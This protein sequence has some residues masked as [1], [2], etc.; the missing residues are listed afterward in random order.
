MFARIL[1]ALP[2]PEREDL[3]EVIRDLLEPGDEEGHGP[4]AYWAPTTNEADALVTLDQGRFDLL[5][6][7]LHLPANR[8][9]PRNEADRRGL[10]LLRTLRDRGDDTPCVLLSPSVNP[11]LKQECDRIAACGVAQ[12]G[13]RFEKGFKAALAQA[14]GAGRPAADPADA[15]PVAATPAER[16][17]AEIEIRFQMPV[18]T[19]KVAITK[20]AQTYSFSGH[21]SIDLGSLQQLTERRGKEIS[22]SLYPRWEKVL[23]DIGGVVLRALLADF[24]LR[25]HLVESVKEVGGLENTRIR[26][27]VHPRIHPL[28]LEALIEEDEDAKFWMLQAAVTR[29]LH[30]HIPDHAGGSREGSRQ[31]PDRLNCLIIRADATGFIDGVGNLRRLKNVAKE[32]DWLERFL[33]NLD[34]ALPQVAFGT[35]RVIGGIESDPASFL[36]ELQAALT[37]GTEWHLIHFAGHSYLDPQD[38]KS[39]LVVPGKEPVR[40]AVEEFA[41]WA[42]GARLIYVSSCGGSENQVILDLAANGIPAVLGFRWDIEDD[43][44][45]EHARIFYRE[46]LT[47]RRPIDQAFLEARKELNRR[48]QT[49]RIWAA[50]ILLLQDD[51]TF[52]TQFPTTPL[53]AAS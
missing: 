35:P 39:Y 27:T 18:Q 19:Y 21:C 25:Q 7:H 30:M 43:R 47:E 44:A 45:A 22:T 12:L 50:P 28:P 36:A 15:A 16:M 51:G 20:G 9:A 34:R 52:F 2:N 17:T 31:T 33:G 5:V 4:V 11:G 38:G 37:D 41:H 1:A 53:R 24:R 46:L 40:I 29:K 13:F 10:A 14:T 42:R 32:C 23:R 48:Y 49:D 6:L 8:K 26:F 3:E